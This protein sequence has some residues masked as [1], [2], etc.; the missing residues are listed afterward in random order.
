MRSSDWSSDVC[1]SDLSNLLGCLGDPDPA[2]RDGIA[3]EALTHWLRAG[4]FDAEALRGLRDRLYVLLDGPAGSGFVRPFAALVLL[5]GRS[6]CRERVCKN[7]LFSVLAAS[8]KT[9]K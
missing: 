7:V 8:L 3:Y 6:S 4:T 2:M 1:S 5:I 9:K